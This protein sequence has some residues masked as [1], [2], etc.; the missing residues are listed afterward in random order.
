[1]YKYAPAKVYNQK[2]HYL[3]T[4]LAIISKVDGTIQYVINHDNTVR[5]SPLEFNIEVLY[6]GKE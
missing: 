1:M 4:G 5:F 3:T 2:G 6:N